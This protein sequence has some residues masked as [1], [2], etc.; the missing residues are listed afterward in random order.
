MKQALDVAT[1]LAQEAVKQGSKAAAA[2]VKSA[3]PILEKAGSQAVDQIK[4]VVDIDS[5]FQVADPAVKVVESGA[6]NAL[7]TLLNSPPIV[8]W[9]E[10]EEEEEDNPHLD[11][12][13]PSHPH[14][15]IY[16][17]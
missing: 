6:N 7:Q 10:E 4:T 15:Q 9:S 11:L 12:H 16:T 14:T 3:T 5:V 1:P 13:T 8:V 17:Q 2:A